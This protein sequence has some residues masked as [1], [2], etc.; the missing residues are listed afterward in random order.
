MGTYTLTYK[1]IHTYI[2]VH[3]WLQ[4]NRLDVALRGSAQAVYVDA[5]GAQ[6]SPHDL[7]LEFGFGA[8]EAS[9]MSKGGSTFPLASV[10][11]P[12]YKGY[13]PLFGRGV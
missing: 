13:M 2:Y 7:A 4:E 8:R 11:S 1:Y 6:I 3:A 12:L 5:G 10:V 9:P